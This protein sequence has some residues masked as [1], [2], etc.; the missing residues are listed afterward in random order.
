M[1]RGIATIGT[2]FA[3]YAVTAI[4]VRLLTRNWFTRY[5]NRPW[6]LWGLVTLA[7][8]IVLYLVV[9]QPW[10]WVFPGTMA[11]IAH[12]LIFPS[13]IA[14]GSTAF[15]RRYRGLGTTLMLAMFDCGNLI[16]SPL[17]GGVLHLARQLGWPAYPTMACGM[18]AWLST[19]AVIYAFFDRPSLGNTRSSDRDRPAN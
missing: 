5:G 14:G 16:G 4:I 7:A 2:F 13:V 12:A 3:A 15:P 9:R 19:M 17:V 1:E 18:A 11:G 10:Q 6:V 8:S